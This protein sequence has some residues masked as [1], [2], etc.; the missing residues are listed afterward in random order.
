MHTRAAELVF[1][2]AV[3]SL[4]QNAP[5]TP[6]FE[7]ASIKPAAPMTGGR[8]M[9]RMGGDPSRIDY[10][11]VSLKDVIARAYNLKRFQV[12]GPAW[13]DTERFDITANVPDGVSRDKIP[14]MLQNLLAERFKMVVHREAKE[15]PVYVLV[16]GK[17]GP[18]LKKAEETGRP[19]PNLPMG[20]G[21]PAEKR[22]QSRMM[23]NS[24]GH[25]EV[26]SATMGSFADMLSNML[27]RP[28]V[29]ET[30]IEGQYDIEMDVSPEDLAGM[31]RVAVTPP[32]HAPGSSGGPGEAGP[33]PE[34]A[35]KASIFTA[36]QQ[37]GLKLDSR[38]APMDHIMV[39][40]AERVPTEN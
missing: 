37:L 26:K 27:D 36:I 35:P 16:V 22:L 20:P 17:G 3:T 12:H 38:K 19:E 24:G 5:D 30:K 21:G 6:A 13:L 34:S 33:A 28:V 4:A 7:V 39:D 1:L 40:R 15:Q 9:V 29:D 2:A 8:L 14:A 10:S 31:R 32:G 25:M 18:K 23:I 11:N